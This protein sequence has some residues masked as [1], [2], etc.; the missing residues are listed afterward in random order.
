MNYNKVCLSV[1]KQLCE[2]LDCDEFA[3]QKIDVNAGTF[4]SISLFLCEKCVS[5][6]RD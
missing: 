5:R 4:G 2:G 3:T 1:N 6:F